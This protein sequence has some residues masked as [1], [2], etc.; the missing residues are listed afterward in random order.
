MRLQLTMN[1]EIR[2][3]CVGNGACCMRYSLNEGK[4]VLIVSKIA[5]N[6]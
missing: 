3:N 2:T 4:T 1:K 5:H 6:F